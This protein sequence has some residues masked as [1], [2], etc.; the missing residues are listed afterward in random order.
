MAQKRKAPKKVNNGLMDQ[1]KYDNYETYEAK[2][3]QSDS[4]ADQDE[5]ES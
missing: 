5:M 2:D 4:E 1:C 3:S